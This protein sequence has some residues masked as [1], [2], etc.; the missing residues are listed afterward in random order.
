[1]K[2]TSL[3]AF[4]CAVSVLTACGGS[5]GSSSKSSSSVSVLPSSSSSVVSSSDQSSSL[6][7]VVEAS[8]SSIE[9]SS[10]VETSSSE[11]SSSSAP[12][13]VGCAAATGLY[14]CDDFSNGNGNWEQLPVAG[15]N[16]EFSILGEGDSAALRYTAAASGAVGGVIAL[17]KPDAFAG[18]TSADYYVEARIRPRLNASGTAQRSIYLMARYVDVNNWYGVGMIAHETNQPRVEIV[19]RNSTGNPASSST[20]RFSTAITLGT[21]GGTDGEW[22]KLRLEMIG[23]EMKMYFNDVAVATFS[24]SSLTERGLIGLF[25]NN[26]SFEID[27]IRVGNPND[28][29]A[30]PAQ[31]SISP[32]T[33]YNAEVNDAARVISVNALNP[34]NTADTFTVESSNPA[35]V[36]VSVTGTSVSLAPVGEGTAVITFTSGSD[37]SLKRTLTATIAPE[38]VQP[39]ATYNLTGLVAPAVNAVNEYTDTSLS[40]TFDAPPTLGTLGSVRIFKTSDDTLVD[41]IKLTEHKDTIGVGTVRTIN[42]RPI[43]ISGNTA[44]IAL[45]SK[46]L[47]YDTSYYVAISPSVFTGA[48]LAGQTFAGIGKNAG[49]TFTTKAAPAANLTSLTVDDDGSTADFRTLQG[50]LNYVMQNL[51]VNDAASIL[52]KNGIYNEPLYLRNKNNLTITGESREGALIAHTNNNGMNPSTNDR[53]VFLVDGADMLTLENLTLKNTTLIGAGGQAETIYFN[54]DNGRLIAKNADFIS[55]QDTLLLKG[56]AWFYNTLVAGSVDFI[57]GTSK[58]A[59]FEKSEIRSTGRSSGNNNGGYILQARVVNTADKGYVFLN[60]RLTSGTGPT[61]ELPIDGTHYLARSGGCSGCIDNIVFINTK[62]GA[63]IN[64][65][66]WAA[67]PAPTPATATANAGWREYNSMDLSGNPLNISS[68]LS[69][70][71]YQLSL[72]EVQSEYCSRAQIFSAYNSGS[73]WNPLSEDI[74][75]CVNVEGVVTSSSSSSSSV[76]SSASETSSTGNSSSVASSVDGGG[77]SSE[78]SSSS[79]SAALVTTTWIPTYVDLQSAVAAA[80]AMNNNA[81]FNATLAPITI[82][83]IKFYS[84][85]AGSLRLHL[86][87]AGTEYAVN[88]NGTSVKDDTSGNPITF[89]EGSSQVNPTALNLAGG[90]TRFVSVPFAPVATPVTLTVTYSNG[91]ATA[92][93][94]CQ[95]G[96]IAIVDQTGKTQKVAT[97]CSNPEQSTI[98]VTVTDATVSELFV[99]MSRNGDGGGGIRIWKIEITK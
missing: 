80:P 69:P 90:V 58:V 68:R 26:R 82:G 47:A 63:H 73:G 14:F 74:S 97:S 22:Y 38:F 77:A 27:D 54:S 57:W 11:V 56:W 87:S 50:A 43:S 30:Q 21:A 32:G 39:T 79:S 51:A 70:A 88:Y 61:N 16:G 19:E 37:A 15:P 33:S 23:T 35:V 24:D 76:T 94:A 42:T 71:S 89:V 31:L 9:S 13:L 17:V 78:A 5:S 7:S 60:S 28:K 6:S 49:W 96:Q 36:S 10:S 81:N 62:M 48:T 41:T 83:G 98:S 45:Y 65:T 3:I 34:Q 75:D 59:L 1:M 46:K 95:N 8:S 66:G 53:A 12:A 64:A 25:T 91:S 40:L 29:P 92:P 85:S 18:V 86:N 84:A 55:E 99:L 2:T 44:T 4:L 72:G 93:G 20:M 67:S 52:L